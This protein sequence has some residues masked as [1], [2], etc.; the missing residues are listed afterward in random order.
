MKPTCTPFHDGFLVFS[1]DEVTL[2][3]FGGVLRSAGTEAEA[4][5]NIDPTETTDFNSRYLKGGL[6][7]AHYQ[8]SAHAGMQHIIYA[9]AREKC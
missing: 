6:C 4:E 8:T 2:P 5:F 3:R 1:R 9:N 7:E